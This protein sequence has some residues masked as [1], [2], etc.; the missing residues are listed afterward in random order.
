MQLIN[1]DT[2]TILAERV[3]IA[4][5]F[6]FRLKGLIGRK[7][8]Q[9]GECLIIMPCSSIHTFFM[10]FPIDVIFLDEDWKIIKIVQYV[11]PWKPALT[12]KGAN[13]VIE[14]PAKYLEKCDPNI[15]VGNKLKLQDYQL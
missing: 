12:V 4:S 2:D 6:L 9:E 10:K 1:L 15:E 7:K 8:L 3:R 14:F 11:K 5:T 13:A